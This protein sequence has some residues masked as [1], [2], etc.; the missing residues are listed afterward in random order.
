MKPSRNS[1]FGKR[2]VGALSLDAERAD[3]E[4]RC[5]AADVERRQAERLRGG[6][7][8]PVAGVAH[9]A[10]EG[11][12]VARIVQGDL[13]VEVDR[14][15]GAR[16][17]PLQDDRRQ[18]RIRVRLQHRGRLPVLRRLV[19]GGAGAEIDEIPRRLRL[20]CMICR[21]ASGIAVG[22]VR[23]IRLSRR[24]RSAFRRRSRCDGAFIMPI[25]WT[26]ISASANDIR[27]RRA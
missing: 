15:G 4:V 17:V 24:G 18:R 3:H 25:A 6:A 7:V 1:C 26:K 20:R 19:R 10:E 11:A 14:L 9:H 16:L 12:R 21:S 23:M 13:A 22:I 2:H 5:S 8:H 27:L